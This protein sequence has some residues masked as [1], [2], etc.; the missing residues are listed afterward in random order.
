[1]DYLPNEFDQENE[2]RFE[3]VARYAFDCGRGLDPNGFADASVFDP[4]FIPI[5]TKEGLKIMNL[6]LDELIAKETY[7]KKNFVGLKESLTKD[8]EQENAIK[9]VDYLIKLIK[10]DLEQR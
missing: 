7:N 5:I 1:M 6:I 2:M 9:L 10:E 3:G 8:I 4:E